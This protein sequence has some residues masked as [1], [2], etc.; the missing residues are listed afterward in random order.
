LISQKR[1]KSTSEF[2]RS[3]LRTE[4]NL[5]SSASSALTQPTTIDI[6]LLVWLVA[7]VKRTLLNI[8]R[9]LTRKWREFGPWSLPTA[10]AVR[11]FPLRYASY[12]EEIACTG[13]IAIRLLT[14]AFCP[15]TL[16]PLQAII[17]EANGSSKLSAGDFPLPTLYASFAILYVLL[18]AV[19]SYGMFQ[20]ECVPGRSHHSFGS[21]MSCADATHF[22]CPFCC[23]FC[24]FG[25]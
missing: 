3:K 6:H 5:P 9:L 7:S 22:F 12:L 25:T 2:V 14:L 17:D 15:R 10:S 20:K 16:S 19:W 8:S 1:E 11:L 23:F 21:F 4:M 13:T 18:T 24:W